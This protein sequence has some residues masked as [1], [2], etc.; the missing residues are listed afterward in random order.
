MVAKG[1][2]SY[3]SFVLVTGG[4]G[5]IGSHICI[6]LI[7]E[8]YKPI[9]VDNF[10]NSH[11]MGLV[12]LGLISKI[13]PI[14]IE[15][16][17]GDYNFLSYVFSTYEIVAVIHTAGLKVLVESVHDPLRYYK[18]N[19]AATLNLLTVMSKYNVKTLVFSSS[20]TVYGCSKHNPRKETDKCSS[21]I[22]YG[23]SKIMVEQILIDICNADSG[24]NVIILRYFNPIG[25]HKSG[26]IGELPTG[27]PTNLMPYITMVAT[28]QYEYLKIFGNNYPTVDG[29]GVR[30][31]IHVM[32]IADGHTCAL[33][34]LYNR[35]GCCSIFNLGF[36]RGIS[37]LELVNTFERVTHQ[38]IPY[39]FLDRRHGD[40]AA[41]W[42][43][44]SLAKKALLW[45][46]RRT[47]EQ[48]CVDAYRWQIKVSSKSM[49]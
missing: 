48:M 2:E 36:G 30:D 12:N 3:M 18:N 7:E 13:D 34:F 31:Y 22:P 14:F 27:T 10:S 11:P 17:I 21:S 38:K 25:A 42:A 19:I 43:D 16:D 15:G 9:I 23:R 41:S 45:Q 33:K 37:V 39:K 49:N 20:A 4:A 24:W 32:D 44:P 5:F 46:P 40:V 1:E 29:T 8:G 47:I 28:K 35:N 26:L 6:S